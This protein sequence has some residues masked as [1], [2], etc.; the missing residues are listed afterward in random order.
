MTIPH[1]ISKTF[2]DACDSTLSLEAVEAKLTL[3]KN[4]LKRLLPE[5]S[6]E[7]KKYLVGLN[8]RLDKAKQ[9]FDM[10]KWEKEKLSIRCQE[11]RDKLVKRVDLMVENIN[12]R[13]SELMNELGNAGNKLLAGIIFLTHLIPKSHELFIQQL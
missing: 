4:D 13:F 1:K 10:C 3:L 6:E 2:D 8:N 7:D 5:F 9:D 12:K 11:Q